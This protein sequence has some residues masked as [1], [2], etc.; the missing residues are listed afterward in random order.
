MIVSNSGSFISDI[1]RFALSNKIK[2]FEGFEGIPGTVGG[3]IVMNAGAYSSVIENV[4]IKVDCIN[5]NGNKMTAV[6]AISISKVMNILQ[7]V[8][9]QSINLIMFSY[10]IHH[11]F[12]YKTM[13]W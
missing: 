7:R 4:I 13:K 8:E 5:K 9:L 11:S 2:G 3:A 12:K 10:F 6:K 1:S